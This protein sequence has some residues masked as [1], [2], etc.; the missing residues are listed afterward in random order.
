MVNFATQ[1]VVDDKYLHTIFSNSVGGLPNFAYHI[2]MDGKY[3]H[4]IFSNSMGGQPILHTIFGWMILLVL[5]FHGYNI[6]LP[7]PPIPWVTDWSQ[8]GH[9]LVTDWSQT[10][11][12][13]VTD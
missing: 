5:K 8:T 7:F 3:L 4:T 10:G 2:W 1:I 9:R 6:C 13:L 11:H 12:R